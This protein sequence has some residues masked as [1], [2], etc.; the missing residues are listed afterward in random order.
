MKKIILLI[1][2]F[3]VASCSK[4]IDPATFVL[5]SVSVSYSD[6]LYTSATVTC[7]ITNGDMATSC[8]IYYGTNQNNLTSSAKLT[9][10]VKKGVDSYIFNV[11]SLDADTKYYFCGFV[12]GGKNDKVSSVNNFTTLVESDERKALIAFYKATGGDNWNYKENWCSD[13]EIDTWQGVTVNGYG[14]VV[15]LT[16]INNNLS[17]NIENI[18]L[19]S[20]RELNVLNVYPSSSAIATASNINHI[21]SIDA[22]SFPSLRILDCSNNNSISAINIQ[23]NSQLTNLNIQRNLVDSL[24]FSKNSKISELTCYYNKLE[25]LNIRNLS[26]LTSLECG[27]QNVSQP[28]ILYMTNAQQSLWD[29]SWSTY[30]TNKEV[31]TYT[32]VVAVNT[33]IPYDI[34]QDSAKSGGVVTVLEDNI[35]IVDKGICWSTMAQ[36]T[37]DLST[38]SSAGS[39]SGSFVCNISSLSGNTLYYV[40][41]YAVGS[42]E[43][44]YYGEEYSFTTLLTGDNEDIGNNDYEW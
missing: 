35:S 2:I 39:G 27:N 41:A 20:L 37:V 12:T 43:I 14:N 16:L 13:K 21:D 9:A 22:S 30:D 25:Y 4:D 31:S 36:P 26:N 11:N 32:S 23:N 29:S 7:T 17:G 8:G 44:V 33:K 3:I 5:P 15:S 10:A 28:L 38:K 19:S 42:N 6:V 40:R 1:S 24:V 18:Y 34:T